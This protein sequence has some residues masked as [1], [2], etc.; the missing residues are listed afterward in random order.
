MRKLVS[1]VL[2][3]NGCLSMLIAL[4]VFVANLFV[5]SWTLLGLCCL[6]TAVGAYSLSSSIRLRHTSSDDPLGPELED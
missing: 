6:F 4:V 3:L 2:S 5:C 1:L